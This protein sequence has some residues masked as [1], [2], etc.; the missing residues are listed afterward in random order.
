MRPLRSEVR[1]PGSLLI[2]TRRR[3]FNTNQRHFFI[4]NR[5]NFV[6]KR[7]LVTTFNTT[8]KHMTT[9]NTH[10]SQHSMR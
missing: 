5:L 10:I 6:L 3:S 8:H 7:P 9:Y 4:S 2:I 1:L